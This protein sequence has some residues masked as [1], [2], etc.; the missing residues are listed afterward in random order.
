MRIPLI[1]VDAFASS[2]FTGNPAAICPLEAWL[3]DGLMQA[4][5]MENNL[6]ETAFLVPCEPDGDA[7][8]DLR[9]FTPAVEVD[10]CGHATLAA[11]YVVFKHLRNDLEEVRFMSRSGL[12]TVRRRQGYLSLDFPTDP[13]KTRAMPEALLEGLGMAPTHVLRSTR[14]WI[15]VLDN[16]AEVAA[17]APDFRRLGALKDSGIIATAPG[18]TVDFVLRFFAPA[19]GID[20]DPVTGSAYTAAG[21]YWAER[22][23]QPE[24]SA[25]QISSRGGDLRLTVRKNRI[26]IEGRCVEVLAGELIL[27]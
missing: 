4:I 20:E 18:E 26:L 1:Q 9:W 24:L 3:D 23:D 2:R 10:L 6:S 21:P 19:L 13:P 15:A 16:E 11:A 5:A 14:D 17:L 12:L 8:Y 27:E 25:R 22:L 7:D